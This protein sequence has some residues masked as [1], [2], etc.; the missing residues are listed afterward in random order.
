MKS[1]ELTLD[2]G[3]I[4]SGYLNKQ[5][6]QNKQVTGKVQPRASQTFGLQST[7]FQQR[8]RQK[9][10]SLNVAR[11]ESPA[12]RDSDVKAVSLQYSTSAIVVPTPGQTQNSDLAPN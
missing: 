1:K 4:K 7:P 6:T 2:P 12:K 5:D 3:S 8:A 10:V 9:K 11:A